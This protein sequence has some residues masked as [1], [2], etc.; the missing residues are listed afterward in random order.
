[1]KVANMDANK[2]RII[3]VNFSADRSSMMA[4]EFKPTQQNL[5]VEISGWSVVD[6]M[7]TLV[8]VL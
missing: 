8:M 4:W 6:Q 1:M 5:K 3:T 7:L 2:E